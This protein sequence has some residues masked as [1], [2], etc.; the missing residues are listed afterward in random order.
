MSRKRVRLVDVAERAG[1]SRAAASLV[2]N[3]RHQELR[4][5]EASR[6]RV[7]QA[8]RALGYRPNLAARGLRTNTS[9]TIGLVPDTVAAEPFAGDMIR[10]AIAVAQEHDHLLL[11]G[12]TEGKAW[13]EREVVSAML[14]RQ[15]D[16][17]VF[18]SMFTRTREIPAF[19]TAVPVV[20]L[21]CT[22]TQARLPTV[23]PDERQAG[24]TSA[25][26]LLAAGH[27]DGIYLV[28]ERSRDVIAARER[29]RGIRAAVTAAGTR[30]AGTVDCLWWPQDAYA[31]V[32]RLLARA[33]PTALIC[34]NDR[35]ALGAYQA[36][37]EAGLR[38][39]DD[40]SVVSFDDSDLASWLRPRL[41][42]I[43]LP[44][45]EMGRLAME[46]LV[47]G[48]PAVATHRVPMPLGAHSS[49]SEPAC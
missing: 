17:L 11:M 48:D 14:D 24:R 8:A 41:A 7:E 19:A 47:K 18:A 6:E 5:S 33:R 36:L 10:G 28:G 3:G 2:L 32:S 9:W 35:I 13:L 45:Y 44:H 26:T 22:T 43:A 1:V 27:R 21:N 39:P 31:A 20:L 30:L 16:G 15:I 34:L 25:E 42:S 49:I 37:Q 23:V 46:L 12:E 38:V 29:S 4:I 40:V